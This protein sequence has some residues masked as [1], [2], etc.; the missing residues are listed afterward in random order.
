[1]TRPIKIA[2]FGGSSLTSAAHIQRCVTL[3]RKEHFRVVVVSAIGK[4]TRLLLEIFHNPQD[5][6]EKA[7]ALL[8]QHHAIAQELTTDPQRLALLQQVEEE[9]LAFL[10]TLSQKD[11]EHQDRLLSFGERF[12]VA[13]F[14]I[15]FDEATPVDARNI[16]KTDDQFSRAEPDMAAITRKV[17]N[18]LRPQLQ[19][20]PV[21]L[22][23][24]IGTSPQNK[25]TTLGF[26]GSDL[27]ASL[28][29]GALNAQQV[30][31]FTDVRGVYRAD[32]RLLP[33][34]AFLPHLSYTQMS[35][36]ASLG[37]KVLHERTLDPLQ[38]KKIPLFI[39]SSLDPKFEGTLIDANQG[40][41]FWGITLL[42]G[43]CA[44]KIDPLQK[45][46][47]FQRSRPTKVFFAPHKDHGL[48]A[49]VEQDT[50]LRPLTEI[51]FPSFLLLSILGIS[52]KTLQDA[53]HHM[54]FTPLFLVEG[55]DM[56]AIPLMDSDP[57]TMLQNLYTT[58]LKT[59]KG[60][61]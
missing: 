54:D 59:S 43:M 24:F 25:P 18:E 34:N 46:E 16:I 50:P 11:L 22:E 35:R 4:T 42:E 28:L 55:P 13:L 6:M 61:L 36:L 10:S 47:V 57:S 7:Q 30:T 19:E 44:V 14:S 8:A 1:M 49:I 40:P 58:L 33:D 37:G 15:A 26:E 9:F 51:V 39:R 56:F 38:S 23:G 60:D 45:M 32:P 2:K 48:L 5:R 52:K 20:G 31:I 17:K 21:L 27:T 3:C 53:F 41:D 29:G 12:S